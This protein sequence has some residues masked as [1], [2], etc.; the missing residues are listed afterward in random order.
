MSQL[1]TT[2]FE[3]KDSEEAGKWMELMMM[4]MFQFILLSVSLI[5]GVGTEDAN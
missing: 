1:A 2:C 3:G 5:P 4:I